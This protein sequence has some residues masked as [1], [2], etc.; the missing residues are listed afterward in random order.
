MKIMIE[1]KRKKPLDIDLRKEVSLEIMIPENK[2]K[3]G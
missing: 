2:K 3:E 1:E